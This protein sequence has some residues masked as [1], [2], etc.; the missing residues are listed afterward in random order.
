[1][2]REAPRKRIVRAGGPFNPAGKVCV[3][4]RKTKR[5]TM[6]PNG[7]KHDIK[8]VYGEYHSVWIASGVHGALCGFVRFNN[9]GELWGDCR[10]W[11][12]DLF[13]VNYDEVS[14]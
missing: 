10:Q 14:E 1:M 2:T 8:V 7:L 4:D 5:K 13:A 11:N 9:R 6:F 12:K 3:I